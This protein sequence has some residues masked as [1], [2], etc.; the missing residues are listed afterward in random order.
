MLQVC[1]F[2]P[3]LHVETPKPIHIPQSELLFD[4][5][6]PDMILLERVLRIREGIVLKIGGQPPQDQR[7]MMKIHKQLTMN[8]IPESEAS[9]EYEDGTEGQ[10]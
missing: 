5:L 6:K 7:M 1:I 9:N 3:Y 8:N 2:V 4:Y 10:I